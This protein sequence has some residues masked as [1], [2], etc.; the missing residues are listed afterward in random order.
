[1]GKQQV[2]QY[3]KH[4][5]LASPLRVFPLNSLQLQDQYPKL[6]CWFG[7][8]LTTGTEHAQQVNVR[9]LAHTQVHIRT[10]K[11][12][13][14]TYKMHTHIHLQERLTAHLRTFQRAEFIEHHGELRERG[15]VDLRATCSLRGKLLTRPPAQ[16][17]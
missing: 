2:P 16:V 1:M 11:M 3:P 15:E 10:Q 5:L 13:K 12:V 4:F 6:Q 8:H 7:S 9:Y 17:L 14:H